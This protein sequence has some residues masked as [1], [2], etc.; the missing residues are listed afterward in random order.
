L[1]WA[2]SRKRGKP[3]ATFSD[4]LPLH[5]GLSP[6]IRFVA[7][8]LL[9]LGVI[10]LVLVA[11]KSALEEVHTLRAA[12]NDRVTLASV[13]GAL[14]RYGQDA[15]LAAGYRT[16]RYRD[17]PLAI[18]DARIAELK[19]S[20]VS[21]FNEEKKPTVLS[22]PL[23]SGADVAQRL[24]DSYSSQLRVELWRQE[25]AYLEQLRAYVYA[26]LG[27]E[28]ALRR[29]QQ[30]H[31]AHQQAY[32]RYVEHVQGYDRLNWLDRA[33]LENT[34]L[35]SARLAALDTERIRLAAENQQ[36]YNVYLAQQ[37]A[38][39]RINAIKVTREFTVDTKRL[40]T[41][42][43]PL[44]NH[45][46]QA[47]ALVSQNL[48]SRIWT[49]VVQMLP[50]AALVLLLSIAGHFGIKAMFFYVLAPLATRRKPI[51]LAP[52]SSGELVGRDDTGLTGGPPALS[53]AVSQSLRLAPDEELLVLPD[54]V[55]SSPASAQSRTKW[56][57][58][59][60]CPWT[61]LISGMYGLTAMRIKGGEPVVVSASDDP[62]AEL[63]L[64]CLP[65]GSS[66]V[67]QPRGMAGVLYNTATPLKITRHWRLGSM[68][69]WLTLQLR[70]L[71]F[72]GPATLIVHGSRG[73]RVE[74]A[75]RGRL[76][77]QASTLGFSAN[78]AYSTIR[79]ETFF[80]FYQ[81]KTALLQDRFEGESGYYVYDETPRGGKKSNF[82][83][84][85]L[86]GFSDA[87]LK[88]FGI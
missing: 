68:H 62:L 43:A 58:D 6:L 56:L 34:L 55:Q 47:E 39:D 35:R 21:S 45:L 54:Y 26:G 27:K 84:R 40:D 38:I 24:A 80:P 76:I 5:S 85:G 57:L 2:W 67:F 78:V 53:S 81:G 9:S 31:L 71:V 50:A 63:A 13:D 46:A 75:G 86:E 8:H 87:V 69:A 15:S 51:C 52:D 18:L 61:S 49:P 79:C 22:F 77:S 3:Q 4:R 19:N 11:G 23:P 30:L 32:T 66:M 25:L 33:L 29:L 65:S 37:A 48:V 1:Q 83:E 74:P 12:R 60:S 36:A 88:V 59:W 28:E 16:A 7:R 42:L 82:V 44:K 14:S 10:A 41:V 64:I 72:H 17:A 73:V 20:L 70:Y